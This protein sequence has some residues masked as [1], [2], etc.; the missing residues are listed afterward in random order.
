MA[1]DL[2]EKVEVKDLPGRREAGPRELLL[3]P[4]IVGISGADIFRFRKGSPIRGGFRSP[5]IPG[6]EFVAKVVSIGR[7]VDPSLL[8]RRVVANPV[9]PC[10]K[11]DWCE[12]GHHAL[13]Q[14]T[15]LLGQPPVHGAMQQRFT[16]PSALCIPVPDSILDELAVLLVPL[17]AALNIVDVAAPRIMESAAVIGCG[18]LGILV[19]KCLRAAGA[20]NVIAVDPV[21]Y[22]RK[23]ALDHGA[24]AAVAPEDAPDVV[25]SW[26]GGG[27]EIAVDVSNVSVGS[28]EAV[29]L[30]QPGGRVLL[31]G[32]PED[33]RVLFSAVE[34]RRKEL[35]VRF[36]RRPHE[37]LDRAV[38]LMASGRLTNLDKL[39]THRFDLDQV[40]V[41]FRASRRMEDA[42]IK[43]IIVMP[44]YSPREESPQAIFGNS[45]VAK[46]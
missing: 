39:I 22:R 43:S 17:S 33:D 7:G 42:V 4:T 13:C 18:H 29:A 32:I 40:G 5:H 20:S 46:A 34:A 30:T 24:T 36:V 15:R 44:D 9:S 27:V 14:H 11:C 8:G 3:Q 16:W 31:G 38:A 37:S 10:M 21:A 25:K 23:A 35:T 45:S 26:P 2:P 41:A 6:I 19:T 28:R 1:S 12:R